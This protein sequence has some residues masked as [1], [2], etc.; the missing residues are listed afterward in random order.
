MTDPQPLILTHF[1]LPPKHQSYSHIRGTLDSVFVPQFKSLSSALEA[2]QVTQPSPHATRILQEARKAATDEVDKFWNYFEI[3]EGIA[4]RY[5]EFLVFLSEGNLEGHRYAYRVACLLARAGTTDSEKAQQV[6]TKIR[7]GIES[8]ISRIIST[9]SDNKEGM[10]LFINESSKV[11]A[12]IVGATDECN[13]LLRESREE[14]MKLEN[15]DFDEESFL[16]DPTWEEHKIA[17]QKWRVFKKTVGG[18]WMG[19]SELKDDIKGEQKQFT[20]SDNNPREDS[21]DAKKDRATTN[22]SLRN[23][24]NPNTSN[25]PTGPTVSASTTPPSHK[26]KTSFWQKTLRR[27]MPCFSSKPFH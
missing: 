12:E 23:V 26:V 13:E 11:L 3:V 2:A 15:K 19:W 7:E 14:F 6:M 21:R 25:M 9:I 8:A 1:K 27:I 20:G 16:R 10:S 22:I 18:L 5:I 24:R 17:L 4:E